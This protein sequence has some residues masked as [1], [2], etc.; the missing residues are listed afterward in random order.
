MFTLTVE[1]P[2]VRQE[3]D[4]ADASLRLLCRKEA[5]AFDRVL[6]E[7]HV[8]VNQDGLAKWERLVLEQFLFLKYR[9]KFDAPDNKSSLS[10]LLGE[11]DGA[12]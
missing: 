11:N 4:E 10:D 8:A 9:G 6:R 5:D 1:D 3:V 12:A 7:S 2:K